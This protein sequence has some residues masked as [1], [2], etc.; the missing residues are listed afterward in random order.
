LAVTGTTTLTAAVTLNSDATFT[1]G[2]Y[3][4]GAFKLVGDASI[5]GKLQ[6]QGAIYKGGYEV[7]STADTIDGGTF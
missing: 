4:T 5:A 6:V 2:T 1:L 3:T 7:L